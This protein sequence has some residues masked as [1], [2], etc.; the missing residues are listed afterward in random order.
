MGTVFL[1]CWRPTATPRYPPTADPTVLA[2]TY[3][4]Q[5]RQ[6]TSII[7]RSSLRWPVVISAIACLLPASLTTLSLTSCY[8]HF[9]NL[10]PLEEHA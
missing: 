2:S 7:G 8:V 3:Q 4:S 10:A 1:L 5:K 6:P 9:N